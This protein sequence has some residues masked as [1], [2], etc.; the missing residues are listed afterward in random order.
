MNVTHETSEIGSHYKDDTEGSLGVFDLGKES[1][2]EPE[3]QSNLGGLVEVGCTKRKENGVSLWKKLIE[4]CKT[5]LTFENMLVEDQEAF[6]RRK[7]KT[8]LKILNERQ[9]KNSRLDNLN[10]MG[11][12]DSLSDL[13]VKLLVG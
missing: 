6:K 10:V 8:W 4:V 9:M 7:N 11:V 13:V 2:V 12:G 1:R 5:N 3:T